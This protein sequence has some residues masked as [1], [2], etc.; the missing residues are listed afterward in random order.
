MPDT[1]DIPD[2][3]D[4][5]VWVRPSDIMDG[6]DTEEFI[7][8]DRPG[9][10]AAPKILEKAASRWKLLLEAYCPPRWGGMRSCW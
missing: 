1:P 9:G 7:V 10:G 3:V 5:M 4:D 2:M 6:G 8:C